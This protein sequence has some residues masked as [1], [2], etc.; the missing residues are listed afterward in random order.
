MDRSSSL[1]GRAV[2]NIRNQV[3]SQSAKEFI[4]QIDYSMSI[5]C[6]E[7]NKGVANVKAVNS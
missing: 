5:S 3:D 2:L 7:S 4:F 6:Y 1:V